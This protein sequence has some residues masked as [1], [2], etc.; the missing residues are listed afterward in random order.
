MSDL[1]SNRE[2]LSSDKTSV[3]S[4]SFNEKWL[5]NHRDHVQRPVYSFPRAAVRN[6]HKL[7]GLQP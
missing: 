1:L 4:H 6:Y 5:L 7:A 3:G 2:A